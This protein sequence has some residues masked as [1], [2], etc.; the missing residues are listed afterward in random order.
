MPN[1]RPFSSHQNKYTGE[2]P[3][4]FFIFTFYTRG[5]GLF[6]K[7][8]RRLVAKKWVSDGRVDYTN[9]REKC[10]GS[11]LVSENSKIKRGQFSGRMCFQS[12]RARNCECSSEQP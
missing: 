12:T 10:R 7:L 3:L 1:L 4:T 5:L 11:G 2:T 8:D 9:N 6:N